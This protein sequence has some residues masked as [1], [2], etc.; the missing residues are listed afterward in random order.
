MITVHLSPQEFVAAALIGVTSRARQRNRPDPYK[1]EPGLYWQRE[2][3]GALAECAA[4]KGLGRYWS[5]MGGVRLPDV[6]PDIEVKWTDW[7]DGGLLIPKSD[8][9]RNVGDKPH[10]LVRGA[11]GAYMLVGWAL[12]RE[13]MLGCYW[14]E[15]LRSPC[16]LMPAEHLHPLE[17]LIDAHTFAGVDREG[18]ENDG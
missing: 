4:A 5:G 7:K 3:E 1:A 17:E 16:W 8:S 18:G 14:T 15:K 2:I 13:V 9:K 6:W 12:G 10:L 11:M